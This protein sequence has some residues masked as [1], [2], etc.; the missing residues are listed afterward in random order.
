MVLPGS[1]GSGG[2]GGLSNEESNF[3]PQLWQNAASGSFSAEPQLR[4]ASSKPLVSSSIKKGSL[5]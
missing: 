2:S 4:Q 1:Q 5:G 3:N